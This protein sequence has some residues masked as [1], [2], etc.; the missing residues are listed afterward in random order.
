MKRIFILKIAVDKAI[1]K[2]TSN[3]NKIYDVAVDINDYLAN[4]VK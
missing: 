3:G 2:I 4:L 1:Y